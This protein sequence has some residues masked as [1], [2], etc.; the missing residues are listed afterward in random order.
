MRPATVLIITRQIFSAFF[1]LLLFTAN[2]QESNLSNENVSSRWLDKKIDADGKTTEWNES[3][4]IND[5]KAGFSYIVSNDTSVLYICLIAT[6][7]IIKTKILNAGFSV[8]LNSEGK[9]KRSYAIDFPLP[10]EEYSIA[11]NPE[12]LRNLKSLRLINFLHARTYQLSGLKKG[13]GLYTI[14]N[15]NDAGIKVSLDLT[16]SGSI[17]YETIIP[18]SSILK[19]QFTLLNNDESNIAICFSI[20]AATKPVIL[21]ASPSIG[22]VS[23]NPQS[24][25]RRFTNSNVPATPPPSPGQMEKLFQSSKAWKIIS[26]AKK[27]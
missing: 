3:D 15:T 22:T 14:N 4:F 21:P 16:D 19:N 10:D 23:G 18:F 24:A 17:V 5:A 6:D 12:S 8:F 27:T 20:N 2:A 26:L 1:S 7:E 25:G 9:K 11:N 13:N